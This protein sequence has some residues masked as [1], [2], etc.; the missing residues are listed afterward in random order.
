MIS[1]FFKRKK[2]SS[3]Q[4][5]RHS[6]DVVLGRLASLAAGILS[7]IWLSFSVSYDVHAQE[8]SGITITPPD[9]ACFPTISVE[10]KITGDSSESLDVLTPA[11][12]TVIENSQS[13]PVESL[14]QE[15]RGVLFSLVVNA[16]YDLDIYDADGI[17]RYE[18]LSGVLR[19]WASSRTFS[20]GDTWSFVT[21]DGVSVRAA[22]SAA[23][24][25]AGLNAYQP[26]FRALE[27]GL[28]GLDIAIKAADERV[29]PLGVDKVL[30][31][32]T[33]P[34]NADQID[35][36][37]DLAEYARSAGIRINVW[38]VGDELYLANDQGG[39]LIDLA[40]LTGGQFFHYTGVE[41][42]PDQEAYLSSLGYTYTLTYNS[43]IRETG[44]YP[45]EIEVS[46]PDL[47]VSG[48]SQPFYIDVQPPNPILISPP[49]QIT[50]EVSSAKETSG[51]VLL[52]NH[53][54][55]EIMVE[56]PDGYNRE[57]VASR[58]Y[59]DGIVVDVRREVPFDSLSWDFS[60][61]TE[62]GE[63]II[64]VEVEDVLG[65][66]ARTILTPVQIELIQ[67]GTTPR[68][69]LQQIGIILAALVLSAA[70]LILI[71]WLVRR[72]LVGKD[73]SV[74]KV[75]LFGRRKNAGADQVI[76]SVSDG[77]VLGALIPLGGTG[78]ETKQTLMITQTET[79]IGMDP[80]RADQVINDED[81]S[82]VHARLHVQEGCFWL[83]D[84]DSSTG[85]WVNYTEIGTKHVQIHPGDLIH[86]GSVGFRFTI[87]NSPTSSEIF[88]SKYEPLL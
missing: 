48:V 35:A 75:R 19:G 47:Q 64:Q 6:P 85:T 69:S 73:L 52:P 88:I 16:A 10:F 15:Y 81:I 62:T 46:L 87:K 71:I 72:H 84:M 8:Q 49:A 53:S 17:S 37:S 36:L 33:P 58:L 79:I 54:V 27:P 38:M 34:P 57:I 68:I 22:T 39:A 30:L 43:S 67:P 50:V 78:D 20:A 65:L 86:F 28:S 5:Q 77:Q 80:I 76:A 12:V 51:A 55:W 24:W 70:F 40:S 7:C 21:N 23:D 66:S 4:V 82:D 56:F 14:T 31:Y 29:V 26:D 44:T 61:L 45:L 41:A 11:E 60:E 83:Q 2:S 9:V 74:I 59:V 3:K 42:I 13:I 18:K 1:T 32:I 63:H 25:N